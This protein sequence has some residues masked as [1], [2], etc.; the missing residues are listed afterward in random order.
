M[1]CDLS[2][3]IAAR[4]EQ[5]LARTVEDVL[6]HRRGNTE[7]IVV[8]DGC[9]ADP[10]LAQHPDVTVVRVPESIGQRAA[11]NLAAQ[12][13]RARYVMKLDA[14][15]SVAEG[16]DVELVTTG[17]ELGPDV[18]QIPAQ[19]NLHVWDWMCDCGQ[20]EYQSGRSEC[21]ACGATRRMEIVWTPRRGSTT[22]SWTFTSEPKFQYDKVG[23]AA[24]T[25]DICDVMTSLGAC[26]VMARERFW[27]L[28]GLD[29]QHGSWGSFG[30]EVACKSWLSG[31]RHVVNR[32]TWF[33]HLFRVNQIGFPYPI[34][35]DQQDAARQRARD[36]W[37]GNTWPQQVR[38]LAWLV[39]KFGPE[40]WTQEQID[41]VDWPTEAPAIRAPAPERKGIV[42]YS[43]QSAPLAILDASR[44]T[45]EAAG[46]PIVA[47]TIG[48]ID[49][50]AA[51]SVVVPFAR[52][53]LSMFRQILLGLECLDVDLVYLC[54][55]DVLYAPEHFAFTPARRNITYY[56]QAVWKVNAADGR[57]L[58]YRCSQTSGLCADRRVLL[59]H[60]RRRVARVERDGYQRSMG[61]EPGT[62]QTRHGGIDD[63]EHET[64]MA[65][66]PNVD[67]RH[68]QNLT[69]SRWRQEQF[70][71]RRYTA[72][73][74]EADAVPG[75]GVTAGRFDA[76]LADTVA[77]LVGVPAA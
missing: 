23:Q 47:V 52:G 36:L 74:T 10:P 72:G 7:I 39:R 75:W 1:T 13:S 38:S 8:L 5:F 28:G 54:E 29:E 51:E 77:N 15:C 12:L 69:P 65:A 53:Y 21:P 63:L 48:A 18:T 43:D 66:R 31:G 70:R 2:V 62:R 30:I 68:G 37:C 59:E 46:L 61:F 3:L 45:I 58:H 44:Q 25:G 49:W 60:Y 57:A 56:N 22:T 9:W 34:S 32:R 40:G 14:H 42:Y 64:W 33:A 17:D 67:L 71:N 19:K 76:W 16:F 26:F 6:A 73:W 4:N 20:R 11:I 50:P 24:Q 41:A 35:G 27:A 55:H